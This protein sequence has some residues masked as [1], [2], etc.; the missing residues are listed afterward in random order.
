MDFEFEG[1][2]RRLYY[3]AFTLSPL[4]NSNSTLRSSSSQAGV[5]LVFANAAPEKGYKGITA[6]VIDAETEGITV[7]KKERKL[8][9]KASSTC[10]LT[11]EDVK[12][13]ASCVLGEVG[14]GY[15]YAIEIL[16]E[17]RIGIAGQQVS[18][19][20]VAHL[21]FV[22][23]LQLTIDSSILYLLSISSAR[24]RQGRVQRHHALLEGEETVRNSHRRLP[25][26]AAPGRTARN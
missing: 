9:L 12:V 6:F 20:I 15:K 4:L 7:G 25:G 21:V 13:D 3:T 11:F 14:M 17:G 8:G 5:F 10:P 18:K 22:T 24:N 23:L 16:N 2:E 26:D 19:L 1:G